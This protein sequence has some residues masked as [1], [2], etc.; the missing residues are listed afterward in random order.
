MKRT[1]LIKH[2]LV[3]AIMAA[4]VSGCAR[5]PSN[6]NA[7]NI[8]KHQ[9]SKYGKK[10]KDSVMGSSQVAAVQID[11]MDEIHKH[12]VAVYAYVNLVD[13]TQIK[14]RNTLQKKTFGW[15]FISWENLTNEAQ[16]GLSAR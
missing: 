2:I 7:S 12:Y 10:Y 5:L 3:I 6:K 16:P 11:G 1:S 14:T 4:F 13:G 9:Y 15:K 8:L